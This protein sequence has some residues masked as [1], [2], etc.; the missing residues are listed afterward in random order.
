MITP[1]NAWVNSVGTLVHVP[2]RA[3]PPSGP[4]AARAHGRR[5]AGRR[6]DRA[7]RG[8]ARLA[9]HACLRSHRDRAVHHRLRGAAGGCAA[10]RARARGGKARQGVELITS[11]ELRVVDEEDREVPRDGRTLG[12]IV[13]R[14]N[15]VM[16]GYWNDPEASAKALRG[17]WFRSAMPLWCTPPDMSRSEIATRT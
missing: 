11:G 1:R 15:V 16:K 7:H 2:M 5:A 9:D 13:A 6:D 4:G 14:G 12:E 8:R 3:S 17:G 10:R